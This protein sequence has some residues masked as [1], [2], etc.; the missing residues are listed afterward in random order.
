MAQRPV[1]RAAYGGVLNLPVPSLAVVE[2]YALGGGLEIALSCD[3][4]RR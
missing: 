4:H 2:G 3:H 1:A